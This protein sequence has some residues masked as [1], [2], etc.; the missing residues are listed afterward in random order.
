MTSGLSISFLSY[1]F[2]G[3]KDPS[4]GSAEKIAHAL[5]M[6]LNAFIIALRN[7]SGA[8][9][10]SDPP[11]K[12]SRLDDKRLKDNREAIRIRKRWE[13]ID[14]EHEEARAAKRAKKAQA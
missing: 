1:I 4:L 6:S 7:R 10:A 2:A 5:G 11:R 8:N 9:S 3:K 13:E 14:R 12:A